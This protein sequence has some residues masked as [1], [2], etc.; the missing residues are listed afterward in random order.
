[1]DCLITCKDEINEY[2]VNVFNDNEDSND[3]YED[4]ILNTDESADDNE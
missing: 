1:M 3:E 4:E 2:V